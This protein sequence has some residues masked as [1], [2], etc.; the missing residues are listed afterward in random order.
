M[1]NGEKNKKVREQRQTPVRAK[2]T[3]INRRRIEEEINTFAKIH[4]VC[5]RIGIKQA[6]VGCSIGTRED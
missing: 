1:M 3:V 2:Y 6:V 4:Y 5:R